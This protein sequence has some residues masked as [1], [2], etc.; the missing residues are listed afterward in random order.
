MQSSQDLYKQ[1]TDYDSTRKNSVDV[2]NDA[3]GKYGVPEIRNRVSGLRTT[4]SNTESAL[5][6]VDPSVTGRTQGSLVT[7]A[8]RS[9]QVANE[10]AP[11]A[12]QYGQFSRSLG[13]ANADLTDRERAA[14]LL[15]QGQQS[16]WETGRR[17]LAERYSL[18]TSAEAEQRRREEA[19]R[20]FALETRKANSASSGLSGLGGLLGGNQ[21][22]APA[23]NR[24]GTAADEQWAFNSV[25]NMLSTRDNKGLMDDYLAT[26]A[27]AKNG[28]VGDLYKLQMYRAK[29]PDLFKAKY[30]WESNY[31][32]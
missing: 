20:A 8:Q 21:G 19:D 12:E 1:L 27:S 31:G 26:A 25:S 28:N 16:D 9:K 17:T 32:F 23:R 24:P 3:L 22:G 4:L 30:G 14:Q 11:I 7:E 29:R 5:N 15:A 13:D 6:A 18:A 10:R 2:L